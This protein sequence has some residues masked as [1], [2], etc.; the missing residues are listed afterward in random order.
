M[1]HIYRTEKDPLLYN[2][3]FKGVKH[4]DKCH[5]LALGVA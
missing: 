2:T 3:V 1:N 4:A 5:L